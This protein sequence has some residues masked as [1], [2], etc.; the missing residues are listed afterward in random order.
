MYLLYSS[1][2]VAFIIYAKCNMQ[3]L[4]HEFYLVQYCSPYN[5]IKFYRAFYKIPLNPVKHF[6][7]KLLY[8][9]NLNYKSTLLT[10]NN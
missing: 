8:W 7:I 2:L 6:Q 10:L 3:L 9:F 5:F 1:S 4:T